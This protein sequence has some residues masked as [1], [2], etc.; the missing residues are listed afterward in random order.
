MWLSWTYFGGSPTLALS[1]FLSRDLSSSLYAPVHA[2]LSHSNTGGS[3]GLFSALMLNAT[4]QILHSALVIRNNLTWHV[5]D[6]DI[7]RRHQVA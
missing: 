7:A 2:E 5:V 1:S 4:G 6:A 3:S